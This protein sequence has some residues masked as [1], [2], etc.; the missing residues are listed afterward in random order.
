M[1]SEGNNGW[2][3][4][5]KGVVSGAGIAESRKRRSK[6]RHLKSTA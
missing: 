4:G 1:G 3:R 5:L 6:V 2:V